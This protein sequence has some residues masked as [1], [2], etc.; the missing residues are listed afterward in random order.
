[1]QVFEE[2]GP[3]ARPL[4]NAR[5][6]DDKFQ[7]RFFLLGV[8]VGLTVESAAPHC[9]AGVLWSVGRTCHP[10]LFIISSLECRPDCRSERRPLECTV[11]IVFEG[12][13]HVRDAVSSQSPFG[14]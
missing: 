1:M 13:K 6:T 9:S 8:L 7:K 4:V 2:T 3:P 5:W 12:N 14:H 10:F 11:T